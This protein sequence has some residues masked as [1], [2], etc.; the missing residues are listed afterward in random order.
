M[1]L[2]HEVYGMWTNIFPSRVEVWT[3][4]L[5]LPAFEGFRGWGNPSMSLSL[6]LHAATTCARS[7]S[8]GDTL[9]STPVSSLTELAADIRATGR[10]LAARLPT[11]A[12]NNYRCYSLRAPYCYTI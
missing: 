8:N 6:N 3:F 10:W 12:K 2:G 4:K 5:I 9:E 7:S 11:I 1:F